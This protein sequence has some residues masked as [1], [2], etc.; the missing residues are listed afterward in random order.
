MTPLTILHLT[1]L[2]FG[3][4]AS[5]LGSAASHDLS[6]LCSRLGLVDTDRRP[7]LAFLSLHAQVEGLR[8]ENTLIRAG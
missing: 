7:L 4:D 1:D 3:C 5:G 8:A 2:H 6:L